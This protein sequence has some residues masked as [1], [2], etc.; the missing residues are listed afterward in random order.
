MLRNCVGIERIRFSSALQS[1]QR[2]VFSKM[3]HCGWTPVKCYGRAAPGDRRAKTQ[4]VGHDDCIQR[5]SDKT[6]GEQ[7]GSADVGKYVDDDIRNL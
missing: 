2:I 6:E 3:S 5:R 1:H 4:L 7:S